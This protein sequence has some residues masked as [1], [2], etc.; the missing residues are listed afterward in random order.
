M[1]IS[2]PPQRYALPALFH[3]FLV[4]SYLLAA[5]FL[6]RNAP[7]SPNLQSIP[8]SSPP[9]SLTV[10]LALSPLSTP[11]FPALLRPLTT[12]PTIYIQQL[13]IVCPESFFPELDSRL[14]QFINQSHPRLQTSLVLKPVKLADD[15]RSEILISAAQAATDWVLILDDKLIDDISSPALL[16]LWD[17]IVF[18]SPSLDIYD[19]LP[20]PPYLNST[21]P[22]TPFQFWEDIYTREPPLLLQTSMLRTER[23]PHSHLDNP[24]L[25]GPEVVNESIV[26]LFPSFQSLQSASKM[27]CQ[28]LSKGYSPQVFIYDRKRLLAST[29]WRSL[30]YDLCSHGR[31]IVHENINVEGF[32][33]DRRPGL[34]SWLDHLATNAKILFSVT[35]DKSGLEGLLSMHTLLNSTRIYIPENQYFYTDWIGSLSIEELQHWHTPRFTFTITTFNRPESFRRLLDSLSSGLYFGDSNLNVRITIEKEAN[36]ET[37]YLAQT[38]EWIHGSMQIHQRIVH[39]G[40]LPAIVESW[41]PADNNSYGLLLEDDIELSPLFYAWVKMTILKYRYSLETSHYTKLFGVSLY[42]Q[43]TLELPP[44]GRQPFNAR[45]LFS[46]QPSLNIPTNTPYLSPIPCSWGAIYFP[47]HWREF[48]TY[49]SSRL[50]KPKGTDHEDPVVPNVRSNRW[51]HS[52]KRFFIELVYLRGYVMLYPNFADFVSL[53]TNH[54]EVGSHVHARSAMSPEKRDSFFL[55]LMQLPA[56][57]ETGVS[58]GLL[59]LPELELPNWTDLPVLNLTG[60]LAT[61]DS[62]AYT[63]QK[64]AEEMGLL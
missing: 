28:F 55:P 1:F 44:K 22:R 62:L 53:S 59:D 51:T 23:L 34:L 43:K 35:E 41:Y 11:D 38:F 36:F 57:E 6:L 20:P 12:E 50:D 9:L 5:Y 4:P 29:S 60:S 58:T 19:F 14:S 49:L 7:S 26:F 16:A 31:L 52:W 46:S 15:V 13:V 48:Y 42:Q 10:Y 24:S 18:A 37:Q 2:I 45:T 47:E 64:R 61:L 39:G 21:L 56:I 27:V 17:D 32:V 33:T 8:V 30:D 40:L 25:S 54:L 3:A 63:G